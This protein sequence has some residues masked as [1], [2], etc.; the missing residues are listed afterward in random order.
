V[1][2]NATARRARLINRNTLLLLIGQGISKAG[3]QL[4]PVAFLWLV[5]TL[6]GSA[7]TLSLVMIT[8]TLPNIAFRFI[9]GVIIDRCNKK[10]VL[11]IADLTRGILVSLLAI[12][13]LGRQV[14]LW[15]LLIV[16]AGLGIGDALFTPTYNSV[17]P[18][19][20]AKDQ[21]LSLN[22]LLQM[23]NQGVS[24]IVP[25]FTGIFIT[26]L[27]V[28]AAL[29]LDGGSF[30]IS[31]LSIL[32][33]TLPAAD[34]QNHQTRSVLADAKEGF[35][36]TFSHNLIATL[37]I[38]AAVI[39]FADAL[40][41]IYPLHI[42]RTLGAGVA[43]YGFL[44]AAV[45]VG[46]FSTSLL[47]TWMG[48]RIQLRASFVLTVLIEGLGVLIFAL[49]R[50]LYIDLGAFWLFGAGM[51]GFFTALTTL[52][53]Q[54]ID[55]GIRGRVFSVYGLFALVLMPPGYLTAGALTKITSTTEV[56]TLAGG[57]M[58]VTACCL[59]VY[60]LLQR[61]A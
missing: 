47:Y 50:N 54:E 48:R 28:P 55:E 59:F 52:I 49:S 23:V 57:M 2:M 6:T 32:L 38:A 30:T 8:L 39:N 35:S 53:Q 22:S 21:L 61:D 60:N 58:I 12:L 41:G 11:I 45:M 17:I 4:A 51:A 42:Q 33:L 31:V 3:D 16:A 7:T 27:G 14:S 10:L 46:L 18:L 26:L 43:W 56:L 36:A 44:N 13:M 20:T 34:Q 25:A 24:I 1:T 37:F 19:I 15:H 9:G 29:L 40:V 5:I